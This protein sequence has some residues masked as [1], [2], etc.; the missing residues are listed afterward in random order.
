M[1]PISEV[2]KIIRSL[3][4]GKLYAECPCPDCGEQ[5]LLKDAGLFYLD[6]FSPEAKELYQQQLEELKEREKSI[7]ELRKAI[8]KSQISAQASNIG[9]ILE[10]L[11]PCMCTFP[12]EPDDCRSLFDP[13][14]YLIFDGLSKKGSVDRIVFTDIKTGQSRL[15][16]SQP[17]IRRLIERKEVVWDTYKPR[18][19]NER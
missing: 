19:E 16:G 10:R 18:L 17:Q 13:I 9:F 14:D 11:A 12:F 5:F 7:R 1:N 15:T 4:E 8:K 6:D 2:K 3:E